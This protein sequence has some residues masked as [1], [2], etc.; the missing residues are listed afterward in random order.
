MLRFVTLLGEV[1]PFVFDEVKSV[2][3]QSGLVMV[4]SGVF[5]GINLSIC[6]H[7]YIKQAFL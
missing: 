1:L 7:Y 6:V 5:S 2:V 4:G 3:D